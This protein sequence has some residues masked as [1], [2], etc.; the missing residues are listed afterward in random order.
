ML[1]EDN[2]DIVFFPFYIEKKTGFSFIRNP[3]LTPYSA[4]LFSSESIAI[5]KQHIMM[6]EVLKLL[7]QVDVFE[8]DVMPSL[9]T[10]FKNN[11]YE[12]SFKRT[13]YLSLTNKEVLF[14]NFK[15]PLQRQIKKANKSLHYV[16]KDDINLLF[17]LYQKT[18]AKNSLTV[19]IPLSAFEQIWVVC[20]QEKCGELLFCQD[21]N[22]N[23]HAALFLV[24][25]KK[26]AYYL[27]GGTDAVFY[28]SGAM[29][30]L[31]WHAIEKSI[32]LEKTF[33]DFEG[34]MIDSVNKFFSNFSPTEINYLNLKK[35]KS[36]IYKLYQKFK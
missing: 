17:D 4:F 16:Y 12:I 25:D 2:H 24:Y 15:S 6:T 5:E 13:N 28:G 7:P 29:S 1:Y 23:I 26:T 36:T 27:A 14:K 20:K 35:I 19:P 21:N 10:E 18:F 34:S 8:I 32:L 30:G 11:E 3:H 9:G 22:N 33:F 31:M